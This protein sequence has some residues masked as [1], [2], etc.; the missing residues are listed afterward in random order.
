MARRVEH[1]ETAFGVGRLVLEGDLPLELE[2]PAPERRTSD[3]E[4][5]RAGAGRAG[6]ERGEGG[7]H[8]AVHSP[9]GDLL[10]RYFAG[11]QVAFPL[12]LERF[13][14][15]HGFTAFERDVLRALSR[16]PYGRAVSYGDLAAAAGR[17]HAYRAA[18]SVMARNPLPVI[19]PCHRVVHSDGTI[20]KY[21]FGS[22]MKHD[23][24]TH[25]AVP[26]E[27]D[28]LGRPERA[29]ARATPWS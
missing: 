20:G 9:W 21:G 28:R 3:G 16:V 26:L 2:L 18:G 4:P 11:E 5:S 10:A 7:E 22:A 23:L 15:A 17:P 12:D 6:A 1:Y 19:L 24:L 8:D 27:A 29:R 25:E 14:D 13:L